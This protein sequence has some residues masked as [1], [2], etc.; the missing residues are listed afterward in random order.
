MQAAIRVEITTV[1]ALI[2]AS[3]HQT[4]RIT[5]ALVRPVC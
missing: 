2:Y 5:A 1:A 3:Y 4:F